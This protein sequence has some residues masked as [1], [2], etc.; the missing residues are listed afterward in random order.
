MKGW[1]LQQATDVSPDGIAV[2]GLGW[3][4]KGQLEGWLIEFPARWWDRLPPQAITPSVS[5]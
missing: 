2:V 4:E 1:K 3:N 5:W